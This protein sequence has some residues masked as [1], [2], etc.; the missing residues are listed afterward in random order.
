VSQIW[1][2][3]S[4]ELVGTR[5]WRKEAPTVDAGLVGHEPRQKVADKEVFPEPADPTTTDLISV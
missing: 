5:F 3:H 1:R 2:Q 4:P